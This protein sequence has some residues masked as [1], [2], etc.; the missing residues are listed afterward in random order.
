MKT[1][2]EYRQQA[3]EC[4]RLAELARSPE[5]RAAILD[6]AASWDSLASYR[7]RTITRP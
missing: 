6:I 4:R 1:A 2:H 7:E 5:E 3:D